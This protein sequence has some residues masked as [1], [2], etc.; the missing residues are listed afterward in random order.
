MLDNNYL[1]SEININ[2]ILNRLSEDNFN[3]W[4][5]FESL[6]LNESLH[7]SENSLGQEIKILETITEGLQDIYDYNWDA[8]FPFYYCKSNTIKKD[9][10]ITITKALFDD[11]SD[12]HLIYTFLKGLQADS[13]YN[14]QTFCNDKHL[15]TLLRNNIEN[16]V[17]YFSS[18][19]KSEDYQKKNP[20]FNVREIFE[21]MVNKTGDFIDGYRHTNISYDAN[22]W[23]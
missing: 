23:T 3:D 19:S 6:R 4:D 20:T 12:T 7:P 16:L 17:D 22:G 5:W 13:V 14:C 11:L 21:Y 9:T 15:A 2:E 1:Q 18:K 8:P 10:K